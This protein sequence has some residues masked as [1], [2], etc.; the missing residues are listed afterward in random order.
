[1]ILEDWHRLSQGLPPISEQEDFFRKMNDA[2]REAYITGEIQF[3]FKNENVLW[4]GDA[5]R[6]E[7][8]NGEMVEAGD[9]ALVVSTQEITFGKLLRKWRVPFDAVT[10]VDGDGNLLELRIS[11]QE[12]AIQFELEPAELI[13]HLNSGDR[14]LHID[15]ELLAY[16]IKSLQA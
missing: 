7:E 2:M 1:M 6:L 14:S 11:S 13:V 16:K 4:S 15:A 8:E 12:T 5:K 3:D 10:R 9:G